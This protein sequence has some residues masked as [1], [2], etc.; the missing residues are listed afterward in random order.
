MVRMPITSRYSVFSIAIHTVDII[1]RLCSD[2]FSYR[3]R[4]YTAHWRLNMYSSLCVCM[5]CLCKKPAC[6]QNKTCNCEIEI[7]YIITYSIYLY[8]WSHYTFANRQPYCSVLPCYIRVHRHGRKSRK[9]KC[10]NEVGLLT[11]IRCENFAASFSSACVY[12]RYYQIISFV[13]GA[14]DSRSRA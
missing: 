1:W 7:Y 4:I 2:T 3:H 9:R 6:H 10:L 11:K 13:S 14:D 8:I 12:W 5:Q